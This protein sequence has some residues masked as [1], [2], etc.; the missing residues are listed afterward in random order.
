MTDPN[1]IDVPL[2]YFVS[3]LPGASTPATRLRNIID[4]IHQGRPL[5]TLAL[6]YLQKQG[7]TALQRLALGEITYQVFCEVA[8]AEKT[9]REQATEEERLLRTAA[10]KARETAWTAEY[11]HE[12]QLK[13]EAR[14]MRESDPKFIAKMKNQQLREQ[15]GLNEYVEKQYFSRLMD[16]IHRFDEGNRLTDEDVLWLTTEGKDYYTDILKVAFHER[17]AEF[18]SSEYKRTSDPWMAVNASGHFRK[19]DRAK[20]AHDLLALI[21]VQRCKSPKLRSAISTTHGGVMRDLKRWDEALKL[22]D[23]AH[24]LMPKDFRPCT[25]MGAV[26]FEIGNYDI[27]KN[28]YTKATERGASERSIDSDLRSIF[29]RADHAKR[30]EI[31]SIL[32]HEDSVRYSWANTL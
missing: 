12:C 20:Q 29:L 19:C 10:Q 22:G 5:T 25:L 11:K 1:P 7:L 14:R 17:E 6:E 28:W 23:N 4:I 16:I 31:K 9:K 21:P 13:E 18:Y 30:E 32:L 8:R 2:R 27:A 15:Y 26:N 24:S 3:D